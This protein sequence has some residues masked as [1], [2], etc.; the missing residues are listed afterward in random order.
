MARGKVCEKCDTEKP[1][2]QF[3]TVFTGA[4]GEK[5][6]WCTTCVTT[7]NL[8]KEARRTPDEKAETKKLQRKQYH[9]EYYQKHREVILQRAKD[10][11]ATKKF[12]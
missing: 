9:R 5:G 12:Q 4:K 3:P 8:E 11:Q 6:L 10:F 2:D 7:Y 1:L